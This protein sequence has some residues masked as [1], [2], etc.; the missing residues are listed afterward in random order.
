MSAALDIA[1]LVRERDRNRYLAGLFAPDELRPHLHALYAF[2][3]ELARIRSM[4]SDPMIGEIRLQWWVDSLPAIHAGE[5]PDH[6]VAIALAHAIRHGRLPLAALLNLAEARRFDLYD[7][8]MPSLADLEGYLGETASASIQLV[9]MILAPGAA[10]SGAEAAGLA[11]VGMGIAGILRLLALHR[12]RGQCYVPREILEKHGA[13][14]AD[15]LSAR[16]SD[17]VRMAIAELI[18]H[19]RKRLQQARA[20]ISTIT[21]DAFPAFLPASLA[22]TYLNRVEAA[23][24]AIL[25]ADMEVSQLRRQYILWRSARTHRF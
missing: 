12:A 20:L 24:H 3:S 17:G 18:S 1:G 16:K 23:G 2:D 7:D 25:T 8:P 14:T 4:V 13:S 10:Q 11:G 9:T 21:P 15:L 6:P 22:D 5:P 19:G